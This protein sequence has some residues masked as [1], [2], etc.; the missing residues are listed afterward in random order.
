MY[1][2]CNCRLAPAAAALRLRRRRAAGAGEIGGLLLGLL[3][4]E[5]GGGVSGISTLA[6]SSGVAKTAEP[7]PSSVL[8]VAGAGAQGVRRCPPPTAVTSVGRGP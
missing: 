4:G 5:G 2:R 8:L 3:V 1:S 6:P 7:S